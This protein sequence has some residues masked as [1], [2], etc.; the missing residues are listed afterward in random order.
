MKQDWMKSM[1][2]KVLIDLSRLGDMRKL[3]DAELKITMKN[4]GDRTMKYHIHKIALGC[5]LGYGEDKMLE[6]T[7][8]QY[9]LALV[10]AGTRY[11]SKVY[12]VRKSDIKWLTDERLIDAKEKLQ[13]AMLTYGSI[14]HI[15]YWLYDK[16]N[17]N[18]R[19]SNEL[20]A[21]QIQGII[22]EEYCR[23]PIQGSSQKELDAVCSTCPLKCLGRM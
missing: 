5:T 9:Q 8:K 22:C 7:M 1:F 18:A 23:Y 13:T 12:L 20:Y 14:E 4:I 17:Y 19:V 21:V 16:L 6:E 2:T 15:K 10:E 11:R 3:S